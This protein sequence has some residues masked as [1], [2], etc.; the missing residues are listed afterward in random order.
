[1]FHSA[2]M[3]PAERPARAADRDERLP[4]GPAVIV[5]IVLSSLSWGVVALIVLGLHAAL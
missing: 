1:M 4:L 3:A 2:R 5:I